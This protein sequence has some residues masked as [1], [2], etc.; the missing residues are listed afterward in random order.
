MPG[1]SRIEVV[2]MGAAG[3]AFLKARIIMDP[4]VPQNP[5]STYDYEPNQMNLRKSLWMLSTR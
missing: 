3:R 2:F 4:R 5:P 1:Y